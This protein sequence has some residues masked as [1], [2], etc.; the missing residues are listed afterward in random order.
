[1]H[2]HHLV[3]SHGLDCMDVY[4]RLAN[5]ESADFDVITFNFGL[6]DLGNTSADL[7]TYTTQL[8]AIADRLLQTKAKLLYIYTTPMMPDCCD[9]APLIPSSE[10]A[11]PPKCKRGAAAIYSCDSVVQRLNQA[12]QGVMA[13][14]KIPTLDLH[15]VVTDVCAPKPPHR[16]VNCSICR[17]QPCSFHYNPEGYK[18][19]S[20]PIASA[21]RKLL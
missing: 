5:G 17:M 11:P 2:W 4:L 8:S 16:Y 15:K 18:M 9:G 1:M 20:Q 19:L 13:S 21:I 6:H 12:A 14:R 10:G 7:S 3:R